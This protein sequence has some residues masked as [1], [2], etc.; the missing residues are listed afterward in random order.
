MSMG[1]S[2]AEEELLIVLSS[3]TEMMMD[4]PDQVRDSLEEWIKRR[5][6]HETAI[7]HI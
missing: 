4:L 1:Y 3:F 2:K 7:P 5:I 6:H